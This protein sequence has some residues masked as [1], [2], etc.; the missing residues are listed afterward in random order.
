M[1]SLTADEKRDART[2]HSLPVGLFFGALL[3][4][5]L[6][7]TW[8]VLA[9]HIGAL[10]LAVVVVTFT[11]PTYDRLVG[12][13]KGKKNFAAALMLLLLIFVLVIPAIGLGF[14]LF[15]QA[16]EVLKGFQGKNISTILGSFDLASRLQF[17]RRFVPSFDPS[18]LQVEQTLIKA[19]KQIPGW[20]AAYGPVFFSSLAGTILDFFLMLLAAFYFYVDGPRIAREL[21]RLSPLPD[22]YDLELFETFRNV[23]DATFRGQM[24][25]AV[26]QGGATAIGFWIAGVP[27]T[28]L[29]GA[30]AAV[31]ALLPMAG[32]AL[33]WIPAAIYLFAGQGAHGGGVGWGLFMVGWGIIVVGLIDNVIRPWA[34]RGGLDMPA[35]VL[36]FSVLGGLEAFGFIGLVLG[37]LVFAVLTTLVRI[38][39]I[40][41]A[42]HPAEVPAKT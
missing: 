1:T 31:A 35:V 37:P 38:Y 23:I 12:R 27:G 5:V 36:L 16:G 28:V 11:Y 32:P 39:T 2:L 33:V 17:V 21:V 34:M 26:A 4:L 41:F 19:V 6:Y 42:P 18:G 20:V 22:R 8:R 10:V 14:L 30:V 13:L 9:P 40:A 29:W 24:L 15:Q 25:T 7:A 3:L